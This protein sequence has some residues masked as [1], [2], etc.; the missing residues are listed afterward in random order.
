MAKRTFS[1]LTFIDRKRIEKLRDE[2]CSQ[3]EIARRI[4]KSP[5][6]ISRELRRNAKERAATIVRSRRRAAQRNWLFRSASA[7]ARPT[8]VRSCKAPPCFLVSC[9]EAPVHQ[10][11]GATAEEASAVLVPADAADPA[12]VAPCASKAMP[13]HAP[14]RVTSATDL[15]VAALARWPQF[16]HVVSPPVLPKMPVPRRRA[17]AMHPIRLQ[18]DP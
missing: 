16:K 10:Q 1:Q 9:W 5:S 3:A 17:R 4:G 18:K 15:H 6:T 11:P 13:A 7:A 8:A 14:W 2:G 12:R